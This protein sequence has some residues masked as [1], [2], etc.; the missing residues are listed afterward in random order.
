MPINLKVEKNKTDAVTE[1]QLHNIARCPVVQH[2]TPGLYGLS[3]FQIYQHQQI[4]PHC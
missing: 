1:G 3:G 4:N 2:L